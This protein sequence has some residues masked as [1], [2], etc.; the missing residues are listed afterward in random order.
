M[1]NRSVLIIISHVTE[2]QTA[3]VGKRKVHLLSTSVDSASP[4]TSS[5]TMTSGFCDLL[6]SSRAGMM[7]WMLEIFFSLNSTNAL[8][9]STLA[10]ANKVK[11]KS[12]KWKS[13]LLQNICYESI[14]AYVRLELPGQVTIAEWLT[15]DAQLINLASFNDPTRHV[16]PCR[17]IPDAHI[18]AVSCCN[19]DLW[20]C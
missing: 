20:Q 7:D 8:L 9:Y 3:D 15:N 10:P 2:N 6:A 19:T 13:C 12:T 11:S 1:Q 5:A 14:M 4:S 17:E 16:R 18:Y